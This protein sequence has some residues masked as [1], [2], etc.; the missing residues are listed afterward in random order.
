M[1][2]GP[3]DT[4]ESP[5]AVNSPAM[6]KPLWWFEQNLVHRCRR[7][8][9]AVRTRVYP[10]FL[11]HMGFIGMNPERHFHVALGLLPDRWS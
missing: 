9:W 10:G 6:Q 7:I 8:T 3:I 11:Q 2:G 5:T 1:M 4:R